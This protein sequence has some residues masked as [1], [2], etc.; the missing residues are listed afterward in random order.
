MQKYLS[1]PIT[2][3]GETSQILGIDT[4]N[5]VYQADETTCTV[6]YLDGAEV[7]ITH[8]EMAQNDVSFRDLIKD[9]IL[10]ALST[11]WHQPKFE[12]NLSALVSAANGPVSVT[13]I[14]I[15]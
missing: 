13:A 12:V 4:V 11:S 9:S 2:A 14:E 5:F 8:T 15:G 10:S 3:I 6:R 7:T 1:I